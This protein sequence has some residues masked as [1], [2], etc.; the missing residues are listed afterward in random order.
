MFF[1]ALVLLFLIGR[2]LKARTVQ[3]TILLVC[4]FDH[5]YKSLKKFFLDF[6]VVLQMM[7][8][9]SYSKSLLGFMFDVMDTSL[10]G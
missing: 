5:G 8:V 4:P 3:L 2:L 10:T 7:R 6:L 9:D 1:V